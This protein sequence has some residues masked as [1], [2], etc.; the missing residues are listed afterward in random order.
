MLIDQLF[1]VIFYSCPSPHS[2]KLCYCFGCIKETQMG[3]TVHAFESLFA[4][5]FRGL[6]VNGYQMLYYG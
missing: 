5:C 1:D 4:H 3:E 6:L 2:M